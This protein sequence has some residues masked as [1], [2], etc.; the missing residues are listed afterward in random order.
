M[1]DIVIYIVK[2]VLITLAIYEWIRIIPRQIRRGWGEGKKD[3]ERGKV[4]WFRKKTEKKPL[5]WVIKLKD[6]RVT[7]TG[8]EAKMARFVKSYQEESNL[9]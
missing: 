1:K 7:I 8:G 3:V 4:S 9:Q 6:G 5:I 2:V